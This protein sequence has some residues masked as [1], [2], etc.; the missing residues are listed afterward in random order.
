MKSRS[1]RHAIDDRL[2][3]VLE[4]MADMDP[5]GVETPAIARVAKLPGNEMSNRL[6]SLRLRGLVASRSVNK[7]KLLIWSMTAKGRA[8]VAPRAPRNVVKY[9]P[10]STV[11]YSTNETRTPAPVSLPAPPWAQEGVA[12]W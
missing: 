8:M 12:A 7:S 5:G 1:D 4:A 6:I 10:L 3:I 2:T 9:A 11:G